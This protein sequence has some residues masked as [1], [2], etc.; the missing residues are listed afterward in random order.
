LLATRLTAFATLL[1]AILNDFSE[2]RHKPVGR[3][4]LSPSGGFER[5]AIGHGQ[6]DQRRG[7]IDVE[8]EPVF[9]LRFKARAGRQKEAWHWDAPKTPSARYQGG[10]PR[11]NT[12]ASATE[13]APKRYTN[14]YSSLPEP[15]DCVDEKFLSAKLRVQRS[16]SFS[17]E[18]TTRTGVCVAGAGNRRIAEIRRASPL[19]PGGP[20]RPPSTPALACCRELLQARRQIVE[21]G[22]EKLSIERRLGLFTPKTGANCSALEQRVIVAKF[23]RSRTEARAWLWALAVQQS[24][25]DCLA[26]PWKECKDGH[27]LRLTNA[28]SSAWP[29]HLRRHERG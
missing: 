6:T 13:M 1:D 21:R 16:A 25:N 29:C 12:S 17:G 24:P 10:R 11:S 22:S 2:Q 18:K 28:K 3:R 23:E 15:H 8:A 26:P 7:D 14:E 19:A 20:P 27:R 5:A 9:L 4:S